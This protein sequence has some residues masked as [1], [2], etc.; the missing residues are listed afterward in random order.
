LIVAGEG[1]KI[2]TLALLRNNHRVIV[3]THNGLWKFSLEKHPQFEET[4]LTVN[5]EGILLVI[6][7]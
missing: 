1:M 5:V 2:G 4:V 3:V 6:T 7:N